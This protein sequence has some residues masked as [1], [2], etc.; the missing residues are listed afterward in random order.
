MTNWAA[1]KYLPQSSYALPY[2]IKVGAEVKYLPCLMI[3]AQF[4]IHQFFHRLSYGCRRQ[5]LTTMADKK[6]LFAWLCIGSHPSRSM[7]LFWTF[8]HILSIILDYHLS[9]SLVKCLCERHFGRKEYRCGRSL[10]N[11]KQTTSLVEHQKRTT[12]NHLRHSKSALFR[13]PLSTESLSPYSCSYLWTS[14]PIV[15]LTCEDVSR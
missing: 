3:G 4:S 12:K 10:N 6:P 13:L 11:W 5:K 9:S 7:H 8:I 1:A 15:S 14:A 2:L